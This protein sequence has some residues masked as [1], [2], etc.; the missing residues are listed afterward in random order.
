MQT[1]CELAPDVRI[2]SLVDEAT[3]H[4]IVHNGRGLL[5]DCHSDQ[6]ASG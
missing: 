6:M 1:A 5:I 2:Y 3:S 4:L